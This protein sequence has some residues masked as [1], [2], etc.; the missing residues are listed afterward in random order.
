[1]S[2]QTS[3]VVPHPEDAPRRLYTYADL[4]LATGLHPRKIRRE[5]EEGRM[6]FVETGE[7]RGRMIEG[8]QYLA[9][10]EARRSA[11]GV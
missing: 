1:M 3:E 6:E 10:L 4:S 9:W 11:P 2:T 8:Q 7:Q 5:V